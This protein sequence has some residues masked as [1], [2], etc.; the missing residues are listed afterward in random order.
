[1]A[2]LNSWLSA[3]IL[4][5]L[6]WAL[7]HSLWQ[8][9][10]VA[11]LAAALMTMS[12]RPSVRYV[13]GI[14]ALVLMLAAPAVTFLVLL[15]PAVRLQAALPVK[16][17]SIHAAAARLSAAPQSVM[18]APVAGISHAIERR[19]IA[20]IAQ[21][22]RP[23]PNLL[24]WLVSAWLC[25]VTFFS[26]RFAG[27]F[28]LLQHNSRRQSAPL[29]PAIL[30][31]CRELEQKLGLRRAIRYLECGWLQVPAVIG[32]LRPIVFL[33][34]CALSGLSEAQLRA[35]IAHE[36]AHIRRLDAF[37]NLFQILAE[38]LLFYHP[39]LWW[40]NRRINAERELA[41]DEI[42]IAAAGNRVEYA[43]AL[44]VIAGWA[45]APTFAMAV[46]RG[47]LTERVLHIMG[48]G[49]SGGQR[50]LGLTGSVLF[51]AAALG[52][53]NALF[54][55]AYPV[56]AAQAREVVKAVLVSSQ[57]VVDRAVRQLVPAIA[58]ADTAG[59]K[60][61]PDQTAVD[62]RQA[63]PHLVRAATIQT[64]TALALND[65]PS[66]VLP[67]AEETSTG[68][69]QVLAAAP[70]PSDPNA[71]VRRCA[72]SM[73]SS[74]VLSSN[75][76]LVPYDFI[77]YGGVNPGGVGLLWGG[78]TLEDCLNTHRATAYRECPFIPKMKVQF[79]DPADAGNMQQ[80]KSV[81]LAGDIVSY[82]DPRI[83]PLTGPD[84]NKRVQVGYLTIQNAKIIDRFGS[85]TSAAGAPADVKGAAL[86]PVPTPGG[87]MTVAGEPGFD[88]T[89][90][91]Q[92]VNEAPVYA[93]VV[94]ADLIRLPGYY[95]YGG[96][97][98]GASQWGP[99]KDFR[100][101]RSHPAAAYQ[102]CPLT[103]TM[104]VRFADASDAAKMQPGQIVT[105][106]GD[107]IVATDLRTV[108]VTS[109]R[110]NFRTHISY[111]VVTNAKIVATE[112]APAGLVEAAANDFWRGMQPAIASSNMA[113]GT[114]RCE[115]SNQ[116]SNGKSFGRDVFTDVLSPSGA[117]MPGF[118]C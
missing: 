60:T 106:A 110:N 61:A 38:T 68:S 85:S 78:Q 102:N 62:T 33:P 73:V 16:S 36:L 71:I 108:P 19:A 12:R 59:D 30:A 79:A 117:V 70:A 29:S 107:I 53:A 89:V 10:V 55:I 41:C 82:R 3:N 74:R 90:V 116:Y 87:D 39:A 95:C 101:D 22:Q 2:S 86:V 1:M 9:A 99:C 43:R 63:P 17:V 109:L 64:P 46:N 75:E 34:A 20:A 18:I 77:C 11:A 104:R 54:G 21:A 57:V 96:G 81:T 8:G 91:R 80:G 58:P 94:S 13:I 44:T 49:P 52:A 14:G 23:L 69:V 65:V 31:M 28:L 98:L 26:L 88:A 100:V 76:L 48:R 25:G 93:Q 83:V 50:I 5:A 4:H 72:N 115:S 35:V 66:P 97:A 103:V 15:Q 111:L 7:I 105:L 51:L 113:P 118:N 47:S 27:G 67:T 32:W 37:V 6:G 40:L 45:A 112:D 24:P 56:P 114:W 92:C 84:G 42:A